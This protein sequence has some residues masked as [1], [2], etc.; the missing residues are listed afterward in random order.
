MRL[1][2]SMPCRNGL[3][4]DARLPEYI[5]DGCRA[6]LQSWLGMQLWTKKLTSKAAHLVHRGALDGGASGTTAADN[7]LKIVCNGSTGQLHVDVS[8]N[9]GS[10]APLQAKAC[11]LG[12]CHLSNLDA[13][14][15]VTY[16]AQ[17]RYVAQC[18]QVPCLT[19][20]WRAVQ[21]SASRQT[22][23]VKWV[24]YL[25]LVDSRLTALAICAQ[26]LALIWVHL[27]PALLQPRI[28]STTSW[29]S[30]I[31]QHFRYSKQPG[32]SGV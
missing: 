22:G 5:A 26:K 23:A 31:G 28:Y 25:K 13:V 10:T 16:I 15:A 3:L 6:E 30:C 18:L 12:V 2:I 27:T 9:V 4:H 8:T 32:N 19:K 20:V 14:S 7:V 21:S 29:Q 11:A 24:V 17:A 1:C